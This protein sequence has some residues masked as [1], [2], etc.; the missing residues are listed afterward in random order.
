MRRLGFEDFAE[1][2]KRYRVIQD[3]SNFFSPGDIVVAIETSQ[4]P[5]CVLEKNY[6][7]GAILSDYNVSNCRALTNIEL[8][9]V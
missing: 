6:F 2:G 7:D 8:M 1:R 5:Y 9:E 4:V 3:E